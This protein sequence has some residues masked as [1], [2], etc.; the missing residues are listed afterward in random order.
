M[1]LLATASLAAILL[2]TGFVRRAVPSE[3]LAALAVMAVVLVVFLQ[4]GKLG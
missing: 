4:I 2:N 1:L 3:S